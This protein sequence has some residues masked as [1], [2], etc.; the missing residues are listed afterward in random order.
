MLVVLPQD[1]DVLHA[2]RLW[3]A[4]GS[5][6]SAPAEPLLAPLLKHLPIPLVSGLPALQPTLEWSPQSGLYLLG[7]YAALQLGPGA[8][9]L[10]GAKTAS[11]IVAQQLCGELPALP[12]A[13]MIGVGG[14]HGGD[15]GGVRRQ[16]GS[17]RAMRAKQRRNA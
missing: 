17:G 8:L 5:S 16:G 14:Y 1:G 13:V 3:L 2:D 9:N 10:A 12:A 7:A 15:G 6:L 4:T 11:V